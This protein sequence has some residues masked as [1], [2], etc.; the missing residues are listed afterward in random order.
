MAPMISAA[1]SFVD[2][3]SHTADQI[4]RI[5]RALEVSLHPLEINTISLDRLHLEAS[6]PRI[7]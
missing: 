6:L 5:Y 4:V 7:P 1:D 2:P 3:R